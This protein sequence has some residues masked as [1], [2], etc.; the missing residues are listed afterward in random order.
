MPMYEYFC[1]ECGAEFEKL[2]RFAEADTLPPCP[3]CQGAQT[4]KKLSAVASFALGE[5][6]SLSSGAGC[7]PRGRFR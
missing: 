5:S 4:R 6:G 3:V 7:S 1:T 2:L